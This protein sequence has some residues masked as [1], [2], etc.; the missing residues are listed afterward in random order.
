[1]LCLRTAVNPSG[2]Y[3][4]RLGADWETYYQAKRSSATRRRDRTKRKRLAEVGEVSL[5]NPASDHDILRT[6][7]V[8]MEQKGRAFARMGVANIFAPAG[9]RDFYHALVTDPATR[10][11]TH[12]S[13]LQAGDAVAAVNLGLSFRGCYYHLL[14][15]YDDGE[16]SRF[17][18]GAA[19]LHEIMRFAIEHGDTVFDFTIGDESYKRDWCE[20]KL[21]L[22]DHVAAVTLRGALIALPVSTARGLKRWIKQTP[23]VWRIFS[24]A[25]ALAGPL[26]GRGGGAA[27]P[28]D[29]DAK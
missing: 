17:G 29:A 4:T 7:D 5:V 25:R 9:C 20:T 24:Q 3:L 6:L 2:A 19:H 23:W 21:T 1:L 15:S 12:V 11:M 13:R 27:N 10:P 28:L 16:L 8:L 26:L 22:H 18:P 14:A